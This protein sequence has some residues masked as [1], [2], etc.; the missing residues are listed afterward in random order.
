[1]AATIDRLEFVRRLRGKLPNGWEDQ[2]TEAVADALD[3]A[4][5]S[6]KLAT[7]NDIEAATKDLKLWVAGSVGVLAAFLTAIKYFG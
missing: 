3:D 2:H 6:A 5:K 7:T 1:M 4:L